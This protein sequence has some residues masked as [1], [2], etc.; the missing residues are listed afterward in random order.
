MQLKK[1]V[2]QPQ[3]KVNLEEAFRCGECLH[4][5]QTPHRSHKTVCAQEGIRS[6]A[7]APRCFTPDYTRVIGNID[8]FAQIITF[9][10]SRTAQQRK[11]LLGMLRVQPKGK[12]HAMGTKVFFN[13]RNREYLSNYVSAFVVGYTSAGEVVLAGSPERNKRG[14]IFFAYLRS[15]ST[16]VT[17]AEWKKKYVQMVAKGRINDPMVTGRKDITEDVKEDNYTVP[18]IDSA[19]KSEREGKVKKVNKRTSDVLQMFTF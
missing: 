15:D 12:K 13:L 5:K 9:F 2:K 8:E 6:V 19:P 3:G 14:Q 18:T 7:L 10:Q 17:P 1:P 4:F 11:I 16:M